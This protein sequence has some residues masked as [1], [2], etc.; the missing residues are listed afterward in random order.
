MSR[1]TN[2]SGVATTLLAACSFLAACGGD[3]P[4]PSV[5]T[6]TTTETVTAETIVAEA[7][8]ETVTATVTATPKTEDPVDGDADSEAIS[9]PSDEEPA[10]ESGNLRLVDFFEP[11]TGWEE[12]RYNVAS[13]T[14]VPG[15]GSEFCANVGDLEL[16]LENKFDR[17][18][19]S[20]GQ[21]ND[22]D[23][24]DNDV[25]V[26]VLGNNEQLQVYIVPFNTI[27]EF[28]LDVRGVNALTI[29]SDCSN[30]VNLVFMDFEL[31]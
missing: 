8:T 6:V 26:E 28:D 21:G 24:S 1:S 13:L 10:P 12:S 22:S 5:T 29:Q 4:E 27:Q 16:R 31:Q 15:I 30:K 17:L 3:S 18:N 7:A 14:Q 19:F 20:V 11:A 9:G 25:T 23:V 2:K